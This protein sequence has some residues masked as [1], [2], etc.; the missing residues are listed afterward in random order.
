MSVLKRCVLALV[1][2]SVASNICNSVT[3][4]CK[5]G[6]QCKVKF[7]DGKPTASCVDLIP[8]R[9]KMKLKMHPAPW[10]QEQARTTHYVRKQHS[11]S[12]DQQKSLSYKDYTTNSIDG[13]CPRAF[14]PLGGFGDARENGIDN[15]DD[16]DSRQRTTNGAGTVACCVLSKAIG[17]MELLRSIEECVVFDAGSREERMRHNAKGLSGFEVLPCSEDS[18][19]QLATDLSDCC[20]DSPF[21][22]AAAS[23]TQQMAHAKKML[24]HLSTVSFPACVRQEDESDYLW[25]TAKPLRVKPQ[26]LTALH[27]DHSL[28]N[29]FFGSDSH[30]SEDNEMKGGRA[31]QSCG[32]AAQE[33]VSLMREILNQAYLMFTTNS[34]PLTTAAR[35]LVGLCLAADGK[36][37]PQ[38]MCQISMQRYSTDVLRLGE[39]YH[40]PSV[41][42]MPEWDELKPRSTDTPLP[43][44]QLQLRDQGAPASRRR[45]IGRP[46]ILRNNVKYGHG[47]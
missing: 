42:K 28:K 31:P 23:C 46:K 16:D 40:E 11:M 45:S 9:L 19:K 8:D 1:F 35:S 10:A 7:Q 17:A 30:N 26:V 15:D 37:V 39:V 13:I 24:Y 12:I 18:A 36:Q 44:N 32:R 14:T 34:L 43:G 25:N 27:K 33:T 29:P 21:P 4:L 47:G 22:N 20:T 41:S 38:A 5:D 6:Q 3:S 2:H